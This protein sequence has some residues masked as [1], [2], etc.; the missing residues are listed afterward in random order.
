MD[1]AI[2]HA[3]SW[4][5]TCSQLANNTTSWL[6]I[7]SL[8]S[9]VDKWT[10]ADCSCRLPNLPF[11]T[12]GLP[13]ENT[14][15][16]IAL[17]QFWKTAMNLDRKV[18]S[19]CPQ[20]FDGRLFLSSLRTYIGGVLRWISQL[21]QPLAVLAYQEYGQTAFNLARP[22]MHVTLSPTGD[23]GSLSFDGSIS[24]KAGS[25]WY[26]CGLTT[27]L[28]AAAQQCLV[29]FTEV[30]CGQGMQQVTIYD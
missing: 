13:Q 11:H 30:R 21:F 20:A 9:H 16:C 18:Q 17:S 15:G 3:I 19:C 4:Q 1:M 8:I 23:R 2:W 5:G 29:E 7:V 10:F 24:E 27:W 26:F 28:R 6:L 25:R 14:S 12:I 22:H